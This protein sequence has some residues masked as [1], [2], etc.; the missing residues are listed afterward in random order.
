[1]RFCFIALLLVLAGCGDKS[2]F[3]ECVQDTVKMNE[4][5]ISKEVKDAV[6]FRARTDC[7]VSTGGK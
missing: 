5:Y 2:K 7:L 1:M 4:P 3:E 6:E